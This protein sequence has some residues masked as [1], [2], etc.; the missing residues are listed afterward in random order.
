[1]LSVLSPAQARAWDAATIA[2]G[3]PSRALMQRA[4]SA[5]ATEIAR[6]F[7]DALGHGVAVFAGAGNNGGDAWVVARALAASGVDVRVREVAPPKTDDARAERELAGSFPSPTGGERVLVDGVLGTGAQGPPHGAVAEAIQVIRVARAAGATVVSL[8][9]PSGLD[10]GSG[11][12]DSVTADLTI[13]FGS[14]TRGLLVAR[15]RCGAI[16]VV[17]IGLAASVGPREA[18]RFVDEAW[19]RS[20]VPR[21]SASAHKGERRHVEIVGGAA[22]M[23]G[24]AILAGRA[25]LRAGA[26]LVRVVADEASVPAIQGGLP[27][28]LAVTWQDGTLRGWAH[29]LAIGPGLGASSG[30]RDIIECALRTSDAPA[31]LDADALNAFRGDLDALAALVHGRQVVLTPHPA[32]MARLAGV[33]VREVLERRWEIAGDVAR[34]T[35]AVVLLKGVPTIVAAPDG[36]TVVVARG[37]PALATGGS[38]DVLAGVIATL[39]AQVTH[40]LEAAACGAWAHG[41]A[42]ELAHAGRSPRGTLLSDVLEALAHVWDGTTAA[43]SYPVLAEL[44]AIAG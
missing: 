17:D 33:E 39:L 43:A 4:G 32:E 35:G 41:R 29:A 30:T 2:A 23:A 34:R 16:A 8:D 3:V 20:R 37:T 22:G 25:A 6:R 1:M 14:F 10:A 28:A 5:A 11:A 7:P 44:P 27:E 15:N 13:A 12:G 40:P 19:F 42:A 21:L 9:V 36:R 26:G 18:A 38:G 31:V 24:A